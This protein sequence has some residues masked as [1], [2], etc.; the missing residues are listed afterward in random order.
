MDVRGDRFL[1]RFA[2]SDDFQNRLNKGR[3]ER[4]DYRSS[5]APGNFSEQSSESSDSR[6]GPG[7]T[8]AQTTMDSDY[9]APNY[10]PNF[11]KQVQREKTIQSDQQ[12]R[13]SQASTNIFNKYVNANR[14]PQAGRSDGSSIAN[15]YINNAAASNPLDIVALDRHI[16][17]GPAYHE[18]KS[19]LA[20]LQTYGDKYRNSRENLAQWQQADPMEAVET[21]DFESIYDKTKKDI[22]SIKL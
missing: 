12:S 11:E 3:S 20:G 2:G 6:M 10:G 22:D 17:N 5:R 7:A 15:K 16:R 9:G 1:N 14:T 21:P 19:E 8:T 18:A 13:S 4:R